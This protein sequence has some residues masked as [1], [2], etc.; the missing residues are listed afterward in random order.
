MAVRGILILDFGM[1]SICDD[2]EQSACAI[3]VED[4]WVTRNTFDKIEQASES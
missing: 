1:L 4:I 2:P 3:L